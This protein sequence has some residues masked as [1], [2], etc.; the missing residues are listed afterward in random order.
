MDSEQRETGSGEIGP[1][2]E[3]ADL[4]RTVTMRRLLALA[5]IAG[6]ALTACGGDDAGDTTTTTLS[7]GGVVAEFATAD[8]TFKV[9]L[10]GAAADAARTAFAT[11]TQPGIPNGRI[12]PG[13]GGVNTGHDWHLEEVEFA[14]MAIEVCDGTA[15]YV[16][17]V[18]YNAWVASQGDRYCPWSAELIGVE[19]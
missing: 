5:L 16:D 11:G 10:T 4:R 15:A 13:D 2:P 19:G 8:G 6:F 9:L 3:S 1:E 18:G 14:E 7:D 17:S 12:L